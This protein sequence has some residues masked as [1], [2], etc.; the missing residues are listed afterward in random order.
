MV[1]GR[2]NTL[3]DFGL[4]LLRLG[5]GITFIIIGSPK[6]A[7]GPEE[8]EVV[9]SHA[10]Y[11]GITSWP[12]FWGFFISIAEFFGGFLLI[13]GL[14]FKPAAAVLLITSIVTVASSIGQSAEFVYTANAIAV[15]FVFLSMLFIGAGKHSLDR[16]I[17]KRRR[18]R[19]L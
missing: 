16:N 15:G 6:L 4:L 13:L 14:F 10:A 11:L 9:G 1:T 5:V 3:N 7:G 17:W 19:L 2:Q 12:M 8:W 18:R